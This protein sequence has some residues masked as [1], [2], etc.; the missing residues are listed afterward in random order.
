MKGTINM[1]GITESGIITIQDGEY[2]VELTRTTDKTTVNNDPM[3]SI[4]LTILEGK[5]NKGNWIWDNIILSKNPSSPGYK[6][7]GKAKH[8]LHI[9]EEAFDGENVEYDTA[10][11]IG[12]I[13]RVK[14]KNN[15]VS[16]YFP[17][18]NKKSD[19][20]RDEKGEE[21]NDNNND[22]PF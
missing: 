14:I 9:I 20:L 12:K 15:N 3:V 1:S 18:E 10:N 2:V 7:L 16:E 6:M 19:V 5:S 11:W 21:I 4:Q 22:V 17:L 13:F 8:F